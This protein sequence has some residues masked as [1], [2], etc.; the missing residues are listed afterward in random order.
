MRMRM[1]VSGT[2]VGSRTIV[3]PARPLSNAPGQHSRPLVSFPPFSVLTFIIF[4][5][6]ITSPTDPTIACNDD[7]SS[8]A[9]Q[10][11]AN[12]AAGS[13]ITGYWNQIWPHNVGPMVFMFS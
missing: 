8:G 3:L 1:A 13:A 11:T 7:G 9:L 4:S 12:V 6:P 5:N 10:L 2:T